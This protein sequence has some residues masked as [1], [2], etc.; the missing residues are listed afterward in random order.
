MIGGGRCQYVANRI[1]V[2]LNH[3]VNRPERPSFIG[4]L[5]AVHIDRNDRI[6]GL[7]G[8]TAREVM[9]L[10]DRE[11]PEHVLGRCVKEDEREPTEQPT[12]AAIAR[13]DF[14]AEGHPE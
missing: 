13:T 8:P 12:S 11:L 1:A 5:D 3:A 4:N 6:A 2:T 9:R 14:P 7:P 10:F